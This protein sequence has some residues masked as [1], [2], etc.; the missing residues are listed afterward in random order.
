MIVMHTHD[1]TRVLFGSNVPGKSSYTISATFPYMKCVWVKALESIIIISCEEV[2]G[3]RGNKFYPRFFRELLIT[4]YLDWIFLKIIFRSD[5]KEHFG[6]NFYS[7]LNSHKFASFIELPR[8][9]ASTWM[10]VS[11]FHPF[12]SR[13]IS[14]FTFQLYFSLYRVLEWVRYVF[15]NFL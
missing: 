1:D 9:R 5:T 15:R 13:W 10:P 8:A 14:I 6:G 4:F 3:K 12:L 7:L 11:N 2:G